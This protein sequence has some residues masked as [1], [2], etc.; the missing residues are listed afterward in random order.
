M[1]A[2]AVATPFLIRVTV[3]LAGYRKHGGRQAAR[4]FAVQLWLGDLPYFL[5]VLNVTS[6]PKRVPDAFVAMAR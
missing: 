3:Q 4:F 5:S 6:E 1:Q 2:T